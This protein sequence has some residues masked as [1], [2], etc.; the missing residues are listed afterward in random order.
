MGFAEAD[1]RALSIVGGIVLA[2][3]SSCMG[4]DG[5]MHAT[6]GALVGFGVGKTGIVQRKLKVG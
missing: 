4:V 2:L 1:L 5:M 3:V 6:A